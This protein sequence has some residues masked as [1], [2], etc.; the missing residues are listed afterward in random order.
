M[1]SA[2]EVLDAV[3]LVMQSAQLQLAANG[4]GGGYT[5]ADNE[6]ALS[7]FQANMDE[8]MSITV[9]IDE[10]L[11]ALVAMQAEMLEEQKKQSKVQGKT[12]VKIDALLDIVISLSAEGGHAPAII[13]LDFEVTSTMSQEVNMF[14]PMNQGITTHGR[15]ATHWSV[16]AEGP[17]AKGDVVTEAEFQWL[18]AYLSRAMDHD[19]GLINCMQVTPLVLMLIPF[20][21]NRPCPPCTPISFKLRRVS[22]VVSCNRR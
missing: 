15:T 12:D 20:L 13:T 22:I 18:G 21:P 1:A 2:K 11:D 17:A 8:S 7:D 5:A 14:N 4:G 10:K 9:E 3:S 16:V 19:F 6:K